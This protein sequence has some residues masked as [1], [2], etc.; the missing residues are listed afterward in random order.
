MGKTEATPARPPVVTQAEWDAALTAL[1]ERERTVAAAM[2]ELAAARK[3]MPMVRV[4]QDYPLR[5][6]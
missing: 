2:H 3:R 5:G 1:L 4:E 6:S